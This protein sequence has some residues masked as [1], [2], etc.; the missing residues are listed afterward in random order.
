MHL[1]PWSGSLGSHGS[2]QTLR[3]TAETSRYHIVKRISTDLGN[4][5]T[6]THVASVMGLEAVGFS[7]RSSCIS[8]ITSLKRPSTKLFRRFGMTFPPKPITCCQVCVLDSHASVLV[9]CCI[10]AFSGTTGYAAITSSYF[11]SSSKNTPLGVFQP[12]TP[13]DVAII[14]RILEIVVMNQG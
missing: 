11:W 1:A 7:L 14:V 6:I 10:D 2:C 13:Q 3:K 8:L 5:L 9:L 4:L 12:A